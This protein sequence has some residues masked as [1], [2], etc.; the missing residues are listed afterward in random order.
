MSWS[1]TLPW[2]SQAAPLADKILK[3]A[4]AG[5]IPVVSPESFLKI[6]YKAAQALNLTVPDGLLRQAVE[7]IR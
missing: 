6:N 4:A 1:T 3:G 2:G 7:V 5:S